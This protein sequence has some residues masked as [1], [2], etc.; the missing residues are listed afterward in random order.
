MAQKKPHGL[1]AAVD[2]SVK[3]MDWLEDSDLASVELARTYAGRIDEALRAFDEGEI[4]STDLNKV[5]YLGPHMLN[6]LRAL[7][8]APQERK[9][10]TSD[11]P[12]AAN[13][14]DE[15]K[16]RRARAEASAAKRA[17]K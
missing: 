2:A 7:G 4:E 6:T 5:L 3:A 13:P 17:A 12:E 10:L 9:A 15:L 11:S 8:G 1:V 14:F 16:K